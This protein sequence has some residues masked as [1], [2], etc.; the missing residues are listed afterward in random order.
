MTGQLWSLGFSDTALATAARVA[1]Y[2]VRCGLRDRAFVD[3]TEQN[4]GW[5]ERACAGQACRRRSFSSGH[6]QGKFRGWRGLRLED[7]CVIPAIRDSSG[8]V[9]AHD[10]EK[11]LDRFETEAD[12]MEGI[13]DQ[14][15]RTTSNCRERRRPSGRAEGGE[16]GATASGDRDLDKTIALGASQ[17]S[18]A[19][20]AV[21]ITKRLAWRRIKRRFAARIL[22]VQ[23]TSGIDCAIIFKP[24][25]EFQL[26]DSYF[27][28]NA[29]RCLA[30]TVLIRGTY[31]ANC[32]AGSAIE[33]LTGRFLRCLQQ[34]K[35]RRL[36]GGRKRSDLFRYGVSPAPHGPRSP[37][38]I[39]C[40]SLPAGEF[41]GVGA[42]ACS[43][44]VELDQGEPV[45]VWIG[46][47]LI[48]ACL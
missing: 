18:K 16:G 36:Q 44:F 13:D 9:G 40:N 4:G 26:C 43:K 46:R 14:P 10:C 33:K 39:C 23:S 29:S 15:N 41:E 48:D 30:C 45:L 2:C 11:Y 28:L 42:S 7:N 25:R 3:H 6:S 37:Q 8:N 5:P 38:V 22:G 12:G 24:G 47:A 21:I 1:T 35:N 34:T 19:D 27:S 20:Y 32:V 31:C 17:N